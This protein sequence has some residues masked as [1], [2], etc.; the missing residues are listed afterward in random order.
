MF[1]MHDV[2]RQRRKTRF[3]LCRMCCRLK[4]LYLKSSQIFLQK[5]RPKAQEHGGI[6]LGRQQYRTEGPR[7]E[8]P[9]QQANRKTK[10]AIGKESERT[11]RKEVD[12]HGQKS[13][14][15]PKIEMFVS[16]L[17]L[18]PGERCIML[19]R[20]MILTQNKHPDNHIPVHEIDT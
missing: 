4:Q 16:D 20:Q 10:E 1:K 14:S 17:Y 8:P 11:M 5:R 7:I 19:R 18:A 13:R 6:R 12:I 9:R 2:A 3:R 15:W